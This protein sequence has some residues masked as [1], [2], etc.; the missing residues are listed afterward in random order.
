[1]DNENCVNNANNSQLLTCEL[2]NKS[3]LNFTCYTIKSG[4]SKTKQSS[5]EV[6]VINFKSFFYTSDIE[7]QICFDEN[8]QE[9][10]L[11]QTKTCYLYSET[12]NSNN[13]QTIKEFEW[14]TTKTASGIGA[15]IFTICIY[16]GAIYFV[17]MQKE[18]ARTQNAPKQEITAGTSQ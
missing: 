12:K 2:E 1:M 4:A 6:R 16:I 3:K 18:N 11:N 10:C 13:N 14:T 7:Q 15:L 8:V 9:H 5:S 17:Y